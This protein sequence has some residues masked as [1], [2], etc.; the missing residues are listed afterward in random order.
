MKYKV[1]SNLKANGGIYAAGDEVEMDEKEAEV[2]VEDGVL[3]AIESDKETEESEESEKKE[4]TE[5]EK[6]TEEE[7][8]ND[9][10]KGETEEPERE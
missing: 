7:V 6:E 1:L 5:S 4:N 10:P 9:K 2:L 3:E 8:E